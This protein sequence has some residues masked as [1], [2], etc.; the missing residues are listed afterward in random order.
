[1]GVLIHG[2]AAF[3]GQGIV[4]ET[5]QFQ[6]LVDYKIGGT[7]QIIMNNQ[8]GFTTPPWQGRSSYY[9]T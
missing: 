4:Y 3:T 7:I 9:C 1:M 2:D 6:D 5:L 8:L